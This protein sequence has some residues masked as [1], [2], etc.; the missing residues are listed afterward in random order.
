M[1]TDA[2]TTTQTAAAAEHGATDAPKQAKASKAASRKKNAPKT[3]GARK[4]A[5]TKAAKPT[6]KPKAKSADAKVSATGRA[7]S[8]KTAVLD[9]MRR[10][11]GAT[12][13]EIAKATGWQNHSIRGFISGMVAKRMGLAV[14]STKNEQGERTYRLAG[15]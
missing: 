14:E 4:T 8:K 5:A 2:S 7:N 11:N 3:K 1:N 10:K 6:A 13:S 12:M 15:K 9:L